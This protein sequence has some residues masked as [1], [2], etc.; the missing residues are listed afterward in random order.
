MK[1]IIQLQSLVFL[2]FISMATLLSANAQQAKKTKVFLFA[3][4]SNMDGRGDASKL[5]EE[6][7][8][9]LSFAQKRIQFYYKGSV[10]NTKDP[11]IMDGVLD[12]T[13]PWQFVKEKFRLE[14][15]F[16]PELF[17]GINLSKAYPNQNVVF[18]KRSQGGTSLYGAWNAE[19]SIE[20]AKRIKEENKPKL[21]NDFIITVDEQLSKLPPESYELA[22]MI[23]VQ[24]ES[25]SGNKYG[26]LPSETYGENIK[27]LIQKVRKHYDA[28]ELPF[29]MLNVGSNKVVQGMKDAV[30]SMPNVTLVEKSKDPLNEN[31]TPTYTHYWNG[32]PAGHYN[33]IGMKKIGELFFDSYQSNYRKFIE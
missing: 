26:F 33:Y 20:K 4:Q 17:F 25:D 10:Q 30:K 27:K 2:V 22:G 29:L 13:D 19:W 12:V 31:Y 24:G 23:W 18:I 14:K 7:L 1:Q 3:G 16:G 9:G 32:K 28:P 5:T 11:L 21:F 6:D 8:N 15:C